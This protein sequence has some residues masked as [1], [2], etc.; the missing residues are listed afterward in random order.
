MLKRLVVG[1]A[2]PAGRA[3]PPGRVPAPRRPA[4]AARPRPRAPGERSRSLGGGARGVR[5]L[6]RRSRP[7][8]VRRSACDI[9]FLSDQPQS[10]AALGQGIWL[11]VTY[12]SI[13]SSRSRCCIAWS[14]R[15]RPTPTAR[16]WLRHRV[17]PGGP[18]RAR[19]QRE[20]LQIYANQVLATVARRHSGVEG[21]QDFN[22]WI[23]DMELADPALFLPRLRNVVD[24]LVQDDWWFD[25]DV[26]RSRCR[27]NEGRDVRRGPGRPIGAGRSGRRPGRGV[28]DRLPEPAGRPRL[29][30][31]RRPIQA[32]LPWFADEPLAGLHDVHGAASGAA[33]CARKARARCCSFRIGR[34]SRCACRSTGWTTPARCSA[35]PS[36][37]RA[38]RC[39]WRR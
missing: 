22:Q 36:T 31:L 29:R 4:A 38:G 37:S 9:L 16:R 32:V 27:W 7:G 1:P 12:P 30:A 5:P 3:L 26:L 15:R 24:V 25:R 13:P 21:Q 34:G 10:L 8:K 18:A 23:E 28:R 33:G 19:A 39:A 20:H 6:H 11:A 17:L 2:A 14:T 35:A